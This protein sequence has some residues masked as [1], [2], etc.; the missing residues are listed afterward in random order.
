MSQNTLVVVESLIRAI[1]RKESFNISHKIILS[2]KRIHVHKLR[3]DYSCVTFEEKMYGQSIP[4]F[5]S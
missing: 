1:F 5:N 3:I 2:R 4:A